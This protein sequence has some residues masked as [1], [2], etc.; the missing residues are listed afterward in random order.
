[1]MC[2][3]IRRRTWPWLRAPPASVVA[4]TLTA[5]DREAGIVE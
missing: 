5:P 1:M 4:V 3:T 2:S